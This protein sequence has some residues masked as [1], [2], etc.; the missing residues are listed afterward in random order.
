M[1]WNQTYEALM[2]IDGH[3]PY[4]C[5]DEKCNHKARN[6]FGMILHSQLGKHHL[7]HQK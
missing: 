3:E 4:G 2:L 7:N 6:T 5:S 1:G